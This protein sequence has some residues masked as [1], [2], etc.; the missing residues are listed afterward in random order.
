M[1]KDGTRRTVRA[2]RASRLVV[3]VACEVRERRANSAP[4]CA[5]ARCGNKSEVIEMKR[6]VAWVV[7]GWVGAC[8]AFACSDSGGGGGSGAGGAAGTP[9]AVGGNGAG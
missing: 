1:K 2:S 5:P 7:F 8:S 3:P 9:G 4:W 6:E